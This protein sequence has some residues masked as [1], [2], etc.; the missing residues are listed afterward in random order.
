MSYPKPGSEQG[1]KRDCYYDEK[2]AAIS[3]E[4]DIYLRERDQLAAKCAELEVSRDITWEHLQMVSE[5][6][7]DGIKAL[8][9]KLMQRAYMRQDYH[10]ADEIARFLGV[11]E[12]TQHEA[13]D[14]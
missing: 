3:N 10:E 8:L 1:A 13:E 6:W 9:T 14:K 5:H 12:P 11:K 7:P 2:M 4:R